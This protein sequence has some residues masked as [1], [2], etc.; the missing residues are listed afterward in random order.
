MEGHREGGLSLI[1]TDLGAFLA[2]P[3]GCYVVG[4]R[5]LVACP[6]PGLRLCAVWGE[7]DADDARELLRMLDVIFHSQMAPKVDA[8]TDVSVMRRATPAAFLTLANGLAQKRRQ[9]ASRIRRQAFV[10]PRTLLGAVVAGLYD[11]A[12]R[13]SPHRTFDR[14]L[15]ALRW[16][17]RGH[18]PEITEWLNAQLDAVGW[19]LTA[20]EAEA[21]RLASLGHNNKSIAYE[22]G[23]T[24]STVG[25]LLHHAA[26]KLNARSRQELL[27]AY[28]KIASYRT[29]ATAGS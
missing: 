14:S 10:R 8:L 20:R 21:L 13:S 29:N 28:Q 17:G 22:M 24:A 25:V 19:Q 15:D 12:G 27:E 1:R 18:Q 2:M 3:V 16:I 7:P 9:F 23:I 6:D 4:R 11:I 5:V 26:R